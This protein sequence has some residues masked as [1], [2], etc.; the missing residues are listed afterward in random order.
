MLQQ[1]VILLLL[2]TI[3]YFM[4]TRSKTVTDNESCHENFAKETNKSSHE[5]FAN[6]YSHCISPDLSNYIEDNFSKPRLDTE[7]H[8]EYS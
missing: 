6:E 5:N 2:L 4:C 3:V 7:V 8:V 1:L